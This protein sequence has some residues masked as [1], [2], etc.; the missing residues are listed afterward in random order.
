MRKQQDMNIND[1]S[2]KDIVLLA[3]YN[4]YIYIQRERA[5]TV[6]GVAAVERVFGER[7]GVE[8]MY[9]A[10]RCDGRESVRWEVRCGASGDN[11]RAKKLNIDFIVCVIWKRWSGILLY[12][13][14]IGGVGTGNTAQLV[15][16]N[17]YYK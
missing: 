12:Y 16:L 4:I 5:R 10:R 15:Q 13:I 8:R 17:N 6:H 3:D 11:E 7:W 14:F 1:R 9:S 2:S